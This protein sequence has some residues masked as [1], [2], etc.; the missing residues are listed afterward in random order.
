MQDFKTPLRRF[1]EEN[2]ILGTAK[3]FSDSD[4]L[5]KGHVIDSTGIV[6]LVMFLEES[7]PVTVD[8]DDLVPRNLDSLDNIEAFLIRKLGSA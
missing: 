3:S 7:W 4:S 2:F 6:E 5:I 8:D 1:I